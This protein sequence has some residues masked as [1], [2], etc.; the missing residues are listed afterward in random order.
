M[1]CNTDGW[2]S[3]LLGAWVGL[4]W[5]G[6]F[7]LVFWDRVPLCSPGNPKAHCVDHAGLKL[8]LGL[9][10]CATAATTTTAQ[11]HL[12]TMGGGEP[13]LKRPLWVCWPWGR[14]WGTGVYGESALFFISLTVSFNCPKKIPK[15]SFK[16][17]HHKMAWEDNIASVWSTYPWGILLCT[18]VLSRAKLLEK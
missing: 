15:S 13:A 1:C 18:V 11:L 12:L 3:R 16:E 9:K 14:M 8:C 2:R 10:A 6:M 5:V 17:Q 7:G 4:G